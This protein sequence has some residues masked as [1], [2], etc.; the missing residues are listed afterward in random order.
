MAAKRAGVITI[1]VDAGTAKFLVDMD[2]ANAKLGQF[3][4]AAQQA[5]QHGVSGVQATS[6][7]LRVLEGGLNNNLRA[8]ERFTANVLGLGPV[9]QAAF[10]VIGGLAFL[11]LLGKLGEEV[12]KFYTDL[13]DAPEKMAGAWRDLNAPIKLSN[14]ELAVSVDRVNNE[15]AK[16]LGLRQNTLKLA[17]DEARVSADQLAESLNKSFKEF[18]KFAEENKVGAFRQFLGEGSTF[19][20]RQMAGGFTGTAGIQTKLEKANLEGEVG[21]AQAKTPQTLAAAETARDIALH[22]VLNDELADANRLLAQ[23]QK[24]QAG[25]PSHEITTASGAKVFGGAVAGKDMTA[26]ISQMQKYIEVLNEKNKAIDLTSQL[27][28]ATRAKDAAQAAHDNARLDRPFENKIEALKAELDGVNQKIAVIGGT[29]AE[30]VI[31]ESFAE[32]AKAIE[33]IDKGLSRINP[34]LHISAAQAQGVRDIFQKIGAAKEQLA[35]GD[36]IDA[37]SK[38]LLDQVKVQ[39]ML[40]AAI[41][42]GYLAVKAANVESTV[43]SAVGPERYNDPTAKK[44]LDKL[45]GAAGEAFDAEHSKAAAAAVDKLETQIEMEKNLAAA[46]SQGA[47]AIRLVT[48]AYR[49]LE[50]RQQGVRTATGELSE[51]TRKQMLA[52]IG[53]YNAQRDNATAGEIAKIDERVA[54]VKRVTAAIAEG[55]QAERKAV[56]ENKYAEMKRQGVKPEAI[57]AERGADEAENQQRLTAEALK[58]G[59]AYRNQLESVDKQIEALKAIVVTDENRLAIAASLRNLE[60]ERLRAMLDQFVALRNLRDANLKLMADLSIQMGGAKDGIRAFFIEMQTQAKQASAIV[61]E[62]L[63][64]ALD[65]VSDNLTKLMTGQKTAWAKMFQGIGEEVLKSSV[66]SMLQRGLGELGKKLGFE[67]KPD[68]SRS[69]PLWVRMAGIG[70]LPGV[71]GAPGAG[72]PTSA[73]KDTS[74]GGG[75]LGALRR[76][77]GIGVRAPGVGP[78]T[79]TERSITF[80]NGGLLGTGQVPKIA[81]SPSETPVPVGTSIGIGKPDGTPQNPF[82]VRTEGA[83][84]GPNFLQTIG[85]T[86]TG[87]A[88]G[89]AGAGAGASPRASGGP[90]VKGRPYKVGEKGEELFV[91]ETAGHI[92]DHDTTRK[93]LRSDVAVSSFMKGTSPTETNIFTDRRRGPSPGAARVSHATA[94][95]RSLKPRAAGG[96]VS[97][98]EAY[99]VGERGPEPFFPGQSGAILSHEASERMFSET[100]GTH[101]YTIDAR[102]TDPVLTG[103]RVEAAIR[104]AHNSAVGMSIRASRDRVRRNPPGR[105]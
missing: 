13:R 55:A 41:G 97:A 71:P 84:S 3:G 4:R 70:A 96:D 67:G 23:Y 69:N 103:A 59:L 79:P 12:R 39:E 5:G 36:K 11:G 15:I 93:L 35:W 52:E 48:L 7:A 1:N 8:A 74:G 104:A 88:I 87:A 47:E 99:M 25:T 63:N 94:A 86:I 66:K 27:T 42:K 18:A 62:A 14:D 34:K 72:G 51:A 43:M 32:A 40:T 20:V 9:L 21:I 80:G 22:K 28:A 44:D 85:A 37:T 17:L 16:L 73:D 33:E 6:G 98:G 61:E 38:R 105:A 83:G 81:T 50:I 30:K 77:L 90:V 76:I 68:G 24:L 49:L 56:L 54:G 89:S 58:V 2:K 60:N 101:F 31:A 10:P 29:Q 78:G 95:P 57:Q 100:G 65:K 102:G 64:S 91:P 19:D 92:I 53:L 26:A 46:Q 45:R 75:I 82:Y